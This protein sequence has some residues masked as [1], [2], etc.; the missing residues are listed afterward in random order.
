M[1]RQIFER[2]SPCFS[3]NALFA[4]LQRPDRRSRSGFGSGIVAF[5][6][7][8]WLCDQCCRR[9]GACPC[10]IAAILTHSAPVRAGASFRVESDM[11]DFG[12][13]VDPEDID[14]FA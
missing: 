7:A 6:R 3:R 11:A 12:D 13:T 5:L 4:Q 1:S 8:E 14:R 9:A 2:C 10:L